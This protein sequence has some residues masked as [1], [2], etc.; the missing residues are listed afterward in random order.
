[1][2]KRDYVNGLVG[3]FDVH[4]SASHIPLKLSTSPFSKE[5]HWKQTLLY[6]DDV[7][8]AEKSDFITGSFA[9]KKSESNYRE[10]E[11]KLS[12]HHQNKISKFD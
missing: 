9:V 4:F 3:W 1:M 11:I 6:F 7:F 5:T 8:P 2:L 10:L 12:V